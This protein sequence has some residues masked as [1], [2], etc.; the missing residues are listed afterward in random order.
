MKKTLFLAI[1]TIAVFACN[2]EPKPPAGTKPPTE[3]EPF[4]LAGKTYLTKFIVLGQVG[5]DT[6][7][8]THEYITKNTVRQTML[9]LAEDTLYRAVTFYDYEL[10]Y[11]H[12][13]IK[14]AHGTPIEQFYFENE[15]TYYS[16]KDSS[17]I[18]SPKK[19]I[20]QE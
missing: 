19:Y 15:S 10:N 5:L 6:M 2:K 11:P 3:Q 16:G 20:L 18:G 9:E 14:D 4:N 12:L 17:A 1:I 8:Y 13:A 7:C